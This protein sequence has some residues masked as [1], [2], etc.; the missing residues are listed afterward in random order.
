MSIVETPWVED[1][2]D[3]VSAA[4]TDLII[5]TPFFSSE[6]LRKIFEQSHRN[7]KIRFLFGK[8]TA[9]SV[10]EGTTDLLAL[11]ENLRLRLNVEC[12]CI[13][14]LHAKVLVADSLSERPRAIITSSNLTK[15]GLQRNI[16][17][18]VMV[19]NSLARE[20]AQRLTSYWN[21]PNAEPLPLAK[22][23]KLLNESRKIE[24]KATPSGTVF[25]VGG[26]VRPERIKRIKVVIDERIVRNAIKEIRRRHGYGYPKKKHGI[27][28]AQNLLRKIMNRDIEKTEFEEIL[29][30]IN[31]WS[32]T[33]RFSN[34][35]RILEND[36]SRVNKS[37]RMLLD[38]SKPLRDRVDSM[39]H[40]D[41]KLSGGAMG[42]VSSMLFINDSQRFN[43]YNASVLRGLRRILGAC[44]QSAYDG[45][46]YESFNSAVTQ[47]KI[48]FDLQDMEADWVLSYLAD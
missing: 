46:T 22:I 2:E 27:Q 23:V 9:Q 44:I 42:F 8:L 12:K 24:R 18:G 41:Y 4:R 30:I 3:L 28:I 14:N 11:E 32:G 47:L 31:S 20:I 35:S 48:R 36:I 37:L 39:I 33:I 40:R 34:L 26:Y 17:F 21:H 13:E 5:A 10:A 38:E 7:I 15:E 25:S 45:V 43:I 19:E 16:E 29:N 6:V 1:L